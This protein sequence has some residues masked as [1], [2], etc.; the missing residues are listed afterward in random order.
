MF[1]K[2]P[3]RCRLTLFVTAVAIGIG[4]ARA[5]QML[6][7][8]NGY[9]LAV[10]I[11]AGLGAFAVGNVDT[12]AG[13]VNTDAP[14]QAPFP[15]SDR[16]T[17]RNWF[18]GFAKPFV[19]LEMPFFDFGHTYA[20]V[21]VVGALTRGNGDALSSL[22][23]QAARSTTSDAP[24]HAAFE[25]AVVGWHS[26][27]LFAASLGEDAIELSGGRQSF[28]LGDAFLIGTGVANGF[29]R[30]A[31]YLQPRASFDDVA[32][33]KLNLEPVR[34]RLFNLENRVD[35]DLMRGFDQP[36][37]QFL[38]LDIGLF[39]KSEAEPSPTKVG[40]KQAPKA[41]QVVQTTR[42]KKELPD[43]WSAGFEFFHFYDAD[44]TP[45]TFSFP[46]GE[47]SPV[48][49]IFGNR[50]GLNLYSGYLAG[51]LFE[52]D[53]NVLLYSQFALQRND[54]V[55][56]RVKAAAWYV[57][58]A[59]KFSTLPWSPQ[60]NLRYA[61]FSGDPNPNDRLKQSYDPL[62]TTGGSRGFG[63]WFLGEIFGQYI[64]ANTNL[65]LE[66]AHLKLSP[67]DTLDVGILYYNFHFDRPAQFDNALI[68]SK[69]AAQEV[70]FYSVWSAT[71]WLT[72]TG[73]LA[74]AVPGAGLKQAAQAFVIE[75]GPFGRRVGRTMSLAE[76]FLA[77][78]Y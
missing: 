38:G 10:G 12:G 2:R 63:S 53:R 46:P 65:N 19:E 14:L 8:Q 7:D 70:D 48:L 52:F 36:K 59:Y 69:N 4:T 55:D 64:S 28:V 45:E 56:R 37:S 22:A 50:K 40:E 25:D 77:I 30:A 51:S 67:Q 24:Q 6:Y 44:S 34:A 17:A 33:L 74:F 42:V 35:Q 66:M 13:N 32:L 11:D 60:L 5:H 31:L 1:A 47:P 49:S 57:E 29:G 78:K 23:P 18:E 68:T 39:G 41:A 3:A 26:A 72:V 75:N 61:H 20:L 58:P 71:E 27:N 73:V 21:S 16:R 43:L 15:P 54:A 76:L 62:F 9:R